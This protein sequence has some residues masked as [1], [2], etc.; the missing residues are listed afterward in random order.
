M[1]YI[2]LKITFATVVIVLCASESL[3]C[4]CGPVRSVLEEFEASQ[5]VIIAR[6]V[7]VEKAPS[8]DYWFGVRSSR[9]V[10]EKVYKGDVR[11]GDTLVFAQGNG[12]NCMWGLAE[13][14]IG[15]QSL[16]YLNVPAAGSDWKAWSCGRS[17]HRLKNATEDLL[18]LDKMDQVRGKTRVSGQYARGFYSG[19]L[20]VAGRK[21]RMV[22]ETKTFE[23]LT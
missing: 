20:K 21:I 19:E 17:K 11:A 18:Y 5:V 10:V 12:A 2:F 7:S 3:G 14:Q 23:A 9:F 13:E 8:G 6:L 4:T 16:V 15:Q 1:R 22:G